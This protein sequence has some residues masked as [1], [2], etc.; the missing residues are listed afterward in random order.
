MVCSATFHGNKTVSNGVEEIVG[1]AVKV[2]SKVTTV[3]VG[4]RVGVG[5][6]VLSCFDCPPCKEGNET[7]CPDWLG[8]F[9]AS[10]IRSLVV[11]LLTLS[12]R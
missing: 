1:E 9:S 7:Y 4:D 6:Q 10:S 12:P 3:K 11:Y 2:G 8:K 5:A